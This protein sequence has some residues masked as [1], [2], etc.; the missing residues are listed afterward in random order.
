MRKQWA[1]L[2]KGI[3]GYETCISQTSCFKVILR[4][5]TWLMYKTPLIPLLTFFGFDIVYLIKLFMKQLLACF[6]PLLS[7]MC[8]HLKGRK[9]SG[10]T[11]CSSEKIVTNLT[12]VMNIYNT[13]TY[14]LQV[15]WLRLLSSLKLSNDLF[16]EALTQLFKAYCILGVQPFYSRALLFPLLITSDGL[17]GRHC[18]GQFLK[19][20][21]TELS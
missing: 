10:C 18:D 14:L 9:W 2:N 4:N 3:R 20:F 16:K 6:T 5:R 7:P 8:S 15:G 13:R 1:Q 21:W 19:P 17:S 12:R 11:L